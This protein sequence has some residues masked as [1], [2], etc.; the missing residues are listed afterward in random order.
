M[1]VY[2][3]EPASG[4]SGDYGFLV[5]ALQDGTR[6]WREELG[7]VPDD[8]IA[9]Q[10]IPKGHSIGGVLLHMIDV[11]AFWIE[12]AALSR[13]RSEDEMRELFSKEN[14]VFAFRWVVPPRR[15]LSYYFELQDKVRARTL[16]SIK[17][18]PE[19]STVISMEGWT[20]AVTARW[21][22]NHVIAHESY[23]GGQLVMLKAMYEQ[24]ELDN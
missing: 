14:D 7:D 17:S 22:I 5:S 6:H 13:E 9:F 12:T 11:E 4:Y 19:P 10:P 20:T 18:F 3:V 2:D 15:P 21:I 24:S 23:H 8:A 16:E 1:R